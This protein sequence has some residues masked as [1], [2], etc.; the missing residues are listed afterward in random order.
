M[1]R[2][3]FVPAWD[4]VAN[5]VWTYKTHAAYPHVFRASVRALYALARATRAASHAALRAL[6]SLPDEL[7]VEVVRALA[8]V[9]YARLAAINL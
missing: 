6:A 3:S 5:A 1:R 9:T 2:V 8:C 4:L 7:L